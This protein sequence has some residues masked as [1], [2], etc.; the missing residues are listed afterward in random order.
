MSSNT[1][2]PLATAL[3]EHRSGNLPV[4]EQLYRQIVSQAP[5]HAAA[6]NL[7]GAL[8]LQ[9]NRA[10]EAVEWVNRAIA[11]NPTV[12]DYFSHL[13][14]AYGV[15]G[16]HDAAIASLR[17][18]VQ[19]DP[20][21]ANPHYNLGTALR[22][23]GR[24]E[25]AVASF[26]NAI[27]S[28]P[29]A[30][31]SHYNLA[32]ALAELKRPDEAE[33]SYRD[34]LRLKPTYMRAM[35]NLAN[36]LKDRERLGEAVE[37]L[38]GAVAADPSHLNARINLG[39]MLR[40]AGE[41]NE[42]LEYLQSA[43]ALGPTSAE[44]HNNL[45]TVLH[46][47]AEFDLAR[48]HYDRALELDPK[49]AD[50]HF[51]RAMFLLRE[52]DLA[53]GF[54]EYEWR[55][56]CKPFQRPFVQPRWD[57]S[58]L[59]GRTLLLFAEQGL[60]DTLQFVRYAAVARRR[61]GRVVVECQ[62]P[63]LPLLQSCPGIDDLVSFGSPLPHF[64]VQCSLMS[65]VGALGLR[66]EELWEGPYLS[67]DL[68]RVTTWRER[69]SSYQAPRVGVC[70]RGNPKHLFDSQRSFDLRELAPV[71]QAIG[72]PLISLQK[73]AAGLIRDSG[74]DVVD[75][76][77]ELDA[78][79]AFLDTAAVMM[80]LDFVISADTAVA[81]LAGALGVPVWLALS[82]N[83]DWRWFIGHDDSLWYPSMRLFRQAKLNQWQ[84][85]FERMAEEA[86]RLRARSAA[87]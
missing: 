14:A 40:D 83:S 63:L 70:W 8:C 29:S 28:D 46:A 69:L 82:A 32:N 16:N 5:D 19:L 57:G 27:A 77:P 60:G 64:D 33:A 21:A 10:A 35:I 41:F 11:I 39:S 76:G 34:A 85:V 84:D 24:L 22:N 36:L 9:S 74:L 23:A 55:W 45:G 79:G 58:P 53:E 42:A 49:L 78:G 26:R 80:N 51:S 48:E 17:R 25:E 4:A 3:A 30:P 72:V 44:A 50:A 15:L 7:L 1:L 18:A 13:G 38:R 81:H 71:Q 65:L 47:L 54:A 62:E 52:G 56:K 67:A 31:E 6:L 61:G 75:L 43:V 87:S 86:G 12:P 20:R 66:L 37:V 68:A 73:D 59:E 2:D